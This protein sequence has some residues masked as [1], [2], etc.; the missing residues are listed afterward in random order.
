MLKTQNLQ[1]TLDSYFSKSNFIEFRTPLSALFYD[2]LKPNIFYDKDLTDKALNEAY[3]NISYTKGFVAEKERII[4]QGDV[5]EGKSLEMLNSLK[6]EYESQLWSQ[7]NY[8]W[9]VFGYTILVALAMLM[10]L[11]FIQKSAL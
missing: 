7:S 3:K 5:V 8:N 1:Q 11:L 9:I 2:I 4:S 6:N 10:L